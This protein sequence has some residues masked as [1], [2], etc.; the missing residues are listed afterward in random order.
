MSE[1]RVKKMRGRWSRRW[2]VGLVVV[3]IG[4]PTASATAYVLGSHPG[5]SLTAARVHYGSESSISGDVGVNGSAALPS[6]APGCPA[7]LDLDKLADASRLLELNARMHDFGPRPTATPNHQRFVDWIEKEM[8]SLPG[9]SVRSIPMT[10]PRQV[11]RGAAL[12]AGT[13]DPLE[14]IPLAGPVPY[15]EPTTGKGVEAPLVYVPP[16]E[17]FTEEDVAGRIIVRDA[18]PGTIPRAAFTA[19]TWFMYDPDLSLTKKTASDY[20]REWIAFTRNA[21][22]EAAAEAGAAGIVFAHGFPL[23]QVRDQYAPYNGVFWDVPGVYVGVDEGERLKEI[24]AS[25][26]TARLSLKA[27]RGPAKTETL[28]VTLPGL[29]DERIAVTSHTDGINAVWDN[30][31]IAMLAMAEHFA[32]LPLECRPRTLEFTFTTAHLFL[33]EASANDYAAELDA[34]YDE[35][36][37]ALVMAL[38]HLGAREYEPFP[39]PDGLPGRTLKPTGEG[40]MNTFFVGETPY[41]AGTVSESLVANDL[42]RSIVLRG[43]DAPGLHIPPHHSFGGEGTAYHGHLLPTIAFVTGPW[44]LFNPSFGMEAVDGDLFRTQL[45]VFTDL[46]YEL[47]DVPREVIAGVYPVEREARSVVCDADDHGFGLAWC[48]EGP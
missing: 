3:L 2:L 9:T 12:A 11:E 40:E 19:V 22:M 38:E 46:I 39:R 14:G 7:S 48:P 8:R 33:S 31:P 36:T 10:I 18:V 32:A 17:S 25:G 37:V 44:T 28:K 41:L 4:V 23:E 45:A 29:S 24:A 42:A 35:G 16:G 27:S 1:R 34:G 43:A 21:D 5:S 26:G 6:A 15:S 13:D 30:G 47:D 20:E